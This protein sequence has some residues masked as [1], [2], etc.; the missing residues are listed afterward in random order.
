MLLLK[1]IVLY[2]GGFFIIVFAALAIKFYKMS[3]YEYR[4]LQEKY[5]K[6][7]IAIKNNKWVLF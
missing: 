2:V 4:R 6:K 1:L 7:G 5:L 3:N